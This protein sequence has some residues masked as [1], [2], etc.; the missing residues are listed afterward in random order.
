MTHFIGRYRVAMMLK[1]RRESSEFRGGETTWRKFI[2]SGNP[3]EAVAL[4]C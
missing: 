1:T 3:F 2:L 4:R